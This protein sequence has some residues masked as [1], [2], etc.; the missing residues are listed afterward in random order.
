MYVQV[1]LFFALLAASVPSVVVWMKIKP[2]TWV[3][4]HQKLQ[5]KCMKGSCLLR[6]TVSQSDLFAT[7]HVESRTAALGTNVLVTQDF[8]SV[9]Y[10]A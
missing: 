7:M 2:H 9:S 1:I 10:R 4:W 6:C 3:S 5:G 8:T